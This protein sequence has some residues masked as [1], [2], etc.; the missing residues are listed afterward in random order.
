MVLAMRNRRYILHS[1]RRVFENAQL[2]CGFCA[3]TCLPLQ[4]QVDAWAKVVQRVHAKGGYIFA[5]LMH[6]GERCL[7]LEQPLRSVVSQREVRSAARLPAMAVNRCT[8]GLCSILAA[9]SLTLSLLSPDSPLLHAPC[10][11]CL[12]AIA[13]RASHDSLNS[14]GHILAP[15]AV[16]MHRKLY[17]EGWKKEDASMPKVT[18]ALALSA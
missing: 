13:G 15:S 8:V 5:Q 9:S 10:V 7:S 14:S 6:T 16:R 17:I 18:F 1:T 2:S 3:C 11:A 12:V 4:D